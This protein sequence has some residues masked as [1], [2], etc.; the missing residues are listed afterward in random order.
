MAC[1]RYGSLLRTTIWPVSSVSWP[2]ENMTAFRTIV[3]PSPERLAVM[4]QPQN[5]LSGPDALS[6]RLAHACRSRRDPS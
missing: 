3:S 1:W 6:S 5:S 4:P 2:P